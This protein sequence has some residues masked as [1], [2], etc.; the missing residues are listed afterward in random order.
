VILRLNQIAVLEV[1]EHFFVL[2]KTAIVEQFS[3]MDRV[4]DVNN[5]NLLHEFTLCLLMHFDTA[6]DYLY[7]LF[8]FWEAAF[9]QSHKRCHRTEHFVHKEP[10]ENILVSEFCS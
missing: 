8:Y 5:I 10:L 3:F 9:E 1:S 6:L 4:E 7:S 2:V